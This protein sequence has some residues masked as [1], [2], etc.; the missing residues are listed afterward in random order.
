M[1]FPKDKKII[2]FDGVCNLCES[3]VQFIIQHDKKDVFRFVA[4]Q[5]ELGKKIVQYIGIESVNL[6]S[7]L[8]Y[9]PGVAYHYKSNAAIE[10]AKDL[11]GVY[12]FATIF[13][14]LPTS[15]R[16]K[17]YDYVAKNRYHWYGKKESC[18]LPTNELKSKFLE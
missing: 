1:E 7:I 4:L 2:L 14:I 12:Q 10:I 11:T 6:D 17:I 13:R 9:N 8:L 18:L 15:I 5:S 3:S 16:D